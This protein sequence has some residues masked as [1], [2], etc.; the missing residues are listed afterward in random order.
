[1]RT[2]RKDIQEFKNL[3]QNP[4]SRSNIKFTPL[5]QSDDKPLAN[6]SIKQSTCDDKKYWFNYDNQFRAAA[7]RHH[8]NRKEKA[9]ALSTIIRKRPAHVIKHPTDKQNESL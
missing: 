1:M 3:K 5:P 6:K 7:E 8:W 4:N 2:F 9:T